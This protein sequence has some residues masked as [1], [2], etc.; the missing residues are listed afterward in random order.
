MI[1]IVFWE[2]S[3]SHLRSTEVKLPKPCKHAN[4]IMHG[5]I[6]FKF[7]VKFFHD[8]YKQP[9]GFGGGMSSFW[10]KWDLF[11]ELLIFWVPP[12]RKF[13]LRPV[14][15]STGFNWS[16]NWYRMKLPVFNWSK[17]VSNW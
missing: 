8:D 13:P 5:P 12:R 15:T 14:Q 9:I 17:L 16:P 2:R 4:F 11:C 7:G 1:C 3:Y 6:K 10:I